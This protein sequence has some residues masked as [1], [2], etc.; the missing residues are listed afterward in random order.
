MTGIITSWRDLAEGDEILPKAFV[1]RGLMDREALDQ[2]PVGGIG[3]GRLAEGAGMQLNHVRPDRRTFVR[4]NDA[5]I[6]ERLAVGRPV[7]ETIECALGSGEEQDH[8]P[9]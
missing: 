2:H 4:S 6:D 9:A 3:C 7:Q 5:G 8:F 1:Y